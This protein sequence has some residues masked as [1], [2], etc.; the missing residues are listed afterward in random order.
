MKRILC[1][2][3]VASALAGC[4]PT[5]L[6]KPGAVSQDF[7]KDKFDCSLRARQMA[8]FGDVYNP[9]EEQGA[10]SDCMGYKGWSRCAN[11]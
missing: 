7:S 10:F 9:F 6:C 4:A 5:R 11:Q 2:L 3:I 1:V 8:Q